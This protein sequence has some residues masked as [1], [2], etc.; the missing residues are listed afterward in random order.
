MDAA[1]FLSGKTAPV[2]LHSV[3]VFAALQFE[4]FVVCELDPAKNREVHLE[5]KAGDR[6]TRIASWVG[7]K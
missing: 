5:D 3:N 4:M 1:A 7:E 2:F 6:R